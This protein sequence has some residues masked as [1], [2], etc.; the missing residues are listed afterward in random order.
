VQ[1]WLG[2]KMLLMDTPDY[3]CSPMHL[4]GTAALPRNTTTNGTRVLLSI[5]CCVSLYRYQQSVRQVSY[6]NTLDDF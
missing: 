2:W 3:S 6:V 5:L 4:S 1:L